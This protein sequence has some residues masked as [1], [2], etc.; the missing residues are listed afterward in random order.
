MCAT[1]PDR[2][3]HTMRIVSVALLAFCGGWPHPAVRTEGQ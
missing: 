3:A 2:D 1:E